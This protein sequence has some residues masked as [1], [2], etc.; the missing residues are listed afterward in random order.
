LSELAE[1]LPE[2]GDRR[3]DSRPDPGLPGGIP[4]FFLAL[5][6]LAAVRIILGY[7][8]LPLEMLR[9]VNLVLAILFLVVPILGMFF[10]ANDRWSWKTATLFVVG[11][12]MVQFG[13]IALGAYIDLPGP[14]AGVLIAIAQAALGCWCAGLG[15]LLATRIKE[16]N[17]IL[18][19]SIFLAAY[20]FFLVLA[21]WGFTQKLLKVAQ[22]VFT[23]V[24]AQIPAVSTAPTHGVARAGAY[25]GMADLVF[26]AMFFIAL[27]RF[28]MRTRQT[29]YAVIPAL[30]AYLLVVI[31]F[32]GQSIAGFPL[33]ALPAMVPIGLAVLIVNWPEFDL[34]KDEKI[35]T[36]VLAIFAFAFLAFTV[37][38]PKPQPEP[39]P[40]APAPVPQKQAG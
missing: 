5:G 23:K 22:P 1:S 28:R 35:A 33:S 6:S 19:I 15:A 24:A 31:L 17:I 18:P 26:L 10:A 7:V 39:G 3:P 32:G 2:P 34:K 30:I 40:S 29:L 12:L 4:I 13:I 8:S 21:P 20:D 38:R 27:F 25:V 9:P 16:K 11:G 37:T 14:V 36:V